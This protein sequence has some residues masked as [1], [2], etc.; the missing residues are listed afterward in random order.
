MIVTFYDP[1]NMRFGG[2]GERW[3]F[4]VSKRL[5]QRGHEVNIINLKYTPMV[6]WRDFE[7]GGYFNYFELPYVKLPRGFPFPSL[8][9]VSRM[10]REFN[11][12]DIVYFYADAPN[13]LFLK[14]F[15][16]RIR[17]S[18][19]GGF[20]TFMQRKITLQKLYTFIMKY[21]LKVFDAFHVLNTYLLRLLQDWG[22][23]EV[24]FLPNGVDTLTFK[25][26]NDPANSPTFNVLFSGRL[27]EEKGVDVL[28]KII[29][30]INENSNFHDIRFIIVGTGPLKSLVR[31]TVKKYSNVEHKVRL[32]HNNMPRVYKNSSMLLLPSYSEGMPLSI[33]EAQSCG[34]P[35]VGS[36]IPGV[37][38]VVIYGETGA[39]S[40]V[41]S[42]DEFVEGIKRYHKLWR[43]SPNE[44]YSL[45]KKI[46]KH[47]VENYDWTII[48]D[49]FEKMLRQVVSSSQKLK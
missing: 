33:L 34:L 17:S 48:I 11:N 31:S 49:E 44:Y 23:K 25:L 36:N 7:C 15:A 46:R 38:D 19:I 10:V 43:A 26:C 29:R 40:R 2:G 47:V 16:S 12:S 18:L 37:K 41:G 30:Q 20:H 5:S 35:V 14:I 27:S 1:M 39:L 45:C 24:F 22:Y 9:S 32:S 42:V 8:S 4:E 3:L 6:N 13:E 28:I 21:S